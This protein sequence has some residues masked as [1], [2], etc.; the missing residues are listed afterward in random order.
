MQSIYVLAAYDRLLSIIRL[1]MLWNAIKVNEY[2][3][4]IQKR[5]QQTP[6]PLAQPPQRR[7]PHPQQSSQAFRLGLLPGLTLI[8]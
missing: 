6:T 5:S 7:T 1:E 2:R 3:N 4:Q 8:D